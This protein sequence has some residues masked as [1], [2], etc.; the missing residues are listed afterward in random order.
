MLSTKEAKC[1]CDN[2]HCANNEE[3]K[4][5]LK[6]LVQFFDKER[7]RNII[8][9]YLNGYSYIDIAALLNVSI[10]TIYRKKNM[11]YAYVRCHI[12]RDEVQELLDCFWKEKGNGEA[13]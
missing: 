2:I 8:V 1:V 11:L 6:S 9:F 12:T 4:E 3:L 7:D 10:A 13:K 5:K